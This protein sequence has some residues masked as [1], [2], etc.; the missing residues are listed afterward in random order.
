M[1]YCSYDETLLLWDTRNMTAPVKDAS[2]GG[3][4]WRIKWHWSWHDLLAT[5]C[6]HNGFNV[7]NC[8]LDSG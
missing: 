1:F 5:A 3:G 7:V 6:M 4:V 8:N 2:L